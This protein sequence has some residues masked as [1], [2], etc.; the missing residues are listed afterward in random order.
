MP[1]PI[2][3]ASTRSLRS[4]A[5]ITAERGVVRTPGY[6]IFEVAYAKPERPNNDPTRF[7]NGVVMCVATMKILNIHGYHG[8][9]KN[10]AYQALE[11]LGCEI[12]APALDYD[13]VSPEHIFANLKFILVNKRPDIIVG[14]SLGGFYAAVLSAQCNYPVMLGEHYFARVKTS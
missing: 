4:I 8:S 9:P 5:D 3:T 2:L 1:V 7:I 13:N 10:S 14:T 11:A 12:I 6:Y